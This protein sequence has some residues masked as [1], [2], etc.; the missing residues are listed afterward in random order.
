[1]SEVSGITGSHLSMPALMKIIDKSPF[2]HISNPE[3]FEVS[4]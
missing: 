3:E 4:Q 2:K 1:M